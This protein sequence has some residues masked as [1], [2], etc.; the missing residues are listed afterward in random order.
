MK[1]GHAAGDGLPPDIIECKRHQHD[2]PEV[3]ILFIK[4]P[5]SIYGCEGVLMYKY[6]PNPQNDRRH[7]YVAVKFS[8][9]Q[10]GQNR[11]TLALLTQEDVAR[12]RSTHNLFN[13]IKRKNFQ[14]MR[15]I[16]KIY[17]KMGKWIV[18]E[19]REKNVN[20][21]CTMSGEDT[22]IIKMKI[23]TMQ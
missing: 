5:H 6:N 14:D 15:N 22:A 17:S 3:K 13:Y 16:E 11:C 18:L 4:A 21:R 8:V 10:A 9:P 23:K 1:H 19:D 2:S 7:C 12:E 20:F